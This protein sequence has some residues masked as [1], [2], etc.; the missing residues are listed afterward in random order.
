MQKV[1][2]QVKCQVVIEHNI[3]SKLTTS[4]LCRHPAYLMPTVPAK[5]T[6]D[7]WERLEKGKETVTNA[8]IMS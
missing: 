2:F 6:A 5:Q 8:S 1:I 3:Q 4:L 7:L